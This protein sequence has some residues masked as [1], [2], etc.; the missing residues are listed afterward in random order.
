M[1]AATPGVKPDA[2][3]GGSTGLPLT[4]RETGEG[5]GSFGDPDVTTRFKA[6]N[7]VLKGGTLISKLPTVSPAKR[8]CCRRAS[9]APT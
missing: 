3:R 5:R 9:R 7:N 4:D 2:G 1:R 8:A 6:C